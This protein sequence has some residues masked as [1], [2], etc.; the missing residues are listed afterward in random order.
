LNSDNFPQLRHFTVH[1]DYAWRSDVNY[2]EAPITFSQ[3]PSSLRHLNVN[4]FCL[5]HSAASPL[6]LPDFLDSL[7]FRNC[8]FYDEPILPYLSSYANRIGLKRLHLFQIGHEGRRVSFEG[9]PYAK[10]G[11]LKQFYERVEWEDAPSNADLDYIWIQ[12]NPY[13]VEVDSHYDNVAERLQLLHQYW[14]VTERD[15][16]S[17][18]QYSFAWEAT[19]SEP[20][21]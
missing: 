3:W 5:I 11:D 1:A 9:F 8:N 7:T 19:D 17:S 15:V 20:Q 13:E 10:E 2:L 16:A 6:I 21:T 14:Q 4:G 12:S 18:Y